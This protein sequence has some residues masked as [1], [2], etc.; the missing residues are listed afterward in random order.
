[1][2][3]TGR[4]MQVGFGRG[5]PVMRPTEQQR[6]QRLR[7][8][9]TPRLPRE[10]RGRPTLPECTGQQVG[11]GGLAGALTPFERDEQWLGAGDEPRHDRHRPARQAQPRHVRT[12]QQRDFSRGYALAR[13]R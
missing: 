12:R 11:L 3:G 13:H 5:G 7:P 9:R 4:E 6:P 1:M 2:L 10:A 8:R